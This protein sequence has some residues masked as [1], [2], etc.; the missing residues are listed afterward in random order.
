MIVGTP[1]AN[2]DATVVGAPVQVPSK[3]VA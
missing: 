2:P 1:M 3:G